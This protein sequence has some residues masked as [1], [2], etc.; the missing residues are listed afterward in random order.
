MHR[1]PPGPHPPLSPYDTTKEEGNEQDLTRYRRSE[2]KERKVQRRRRC[3]RSRLR[4]V[5]VLVVVENR[6]PRY[7]SACRRRHRRS[8][9]VT[10][11]GDETLETPHASSLSSPGIAVL[12]TSTDRNRG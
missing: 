8:P 4:R 6:D 1:A 12:R 7:E 3:R 5:V 11:N 9:R 2:R 10:T